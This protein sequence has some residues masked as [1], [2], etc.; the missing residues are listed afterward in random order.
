MDII[1]KKNV[2]GLGEV[3][4]LITVKNGYA[5]NYLI[6]R[7]DAIIATDSTKKVREENLRQRAHKIQKVKD[8][9]EKVAKKLTEATLQVGAKVGENGKIFG[10]VT[11]L[12]L[13]DAIQKLGF[14]VERKNITIKNEPIKEIGTFDAVVKLHRDIT[15]EIKFEV[16]GE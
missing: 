4:D 5:R 10:S 11:N 14:E 6:P 9:A 15:A 3:D 7:G 13:A 8:E 1:L 12:Q 16:V 2:D